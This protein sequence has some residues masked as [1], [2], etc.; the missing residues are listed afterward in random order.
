MSFPTEQDYDEIV[1][2][3]FG[4]DIYFGQQ[5]IDK[6]RSCNDL[7]R[8]YSRWI[9]KFMAEMDL[10]PRWEDYANSPTLFTMTEYNAWTRNEPIGQTKSQPSGDDLDT[11]RY[12]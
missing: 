11:S 4:N 12:V 1:A 9:F 2:I 10:S 8:I 5:A 3:Q 6:A 7:T